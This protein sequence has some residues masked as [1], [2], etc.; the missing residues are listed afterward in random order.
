MKHTVHDKDFVFT[1]LICLLKSINLLHLIWVVPK[2]TE[3]WNMEYRNN[4]L[5][6]PP[7]FCLQH[8]LNS[9]S[10]PHFTAQPTKK[11]EKEKSECDKAGPGQS[12]RWETSFSG[13]TA[14][15]LFSLVKSLISLGLIQFRILSGLV[16]PW[17]KLQTLWQWVNSDEICRRNPIRNKRSLSGAVWWPQ[18][19]AA[20]VCVCVCLCVGMHPCSCA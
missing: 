8:A 18:S 12:N 9:W 13:V 3:L 15:I 11:K 7:H 5:F 4:F 16:C 17:N 6:Q 14:L 2:G 19:K 1:P 20:S 10:I